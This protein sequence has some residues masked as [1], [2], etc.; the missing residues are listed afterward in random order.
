MYKHDPEYKTPDLD[1]DDPDSQKEPPPKIYY[2]N[3]NI[4]QQYYN[5][6]VYIKKDTNQTD[7]QFQ[8]TNQSDSQ[9]YQP[10]KT[11][12]V[13][14]IYPI[15]IGITIILLITLSLLLYISKSQGQPPPPV[16]EKYSTKPKKTKRE[17]IFDKVK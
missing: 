8:N 4:F 9:T 6:G 11:R 2:Y 15:F 16:Y 13:T 5:S 14:N 12:Q 7:N 17:T 1:P 3:E 10:E